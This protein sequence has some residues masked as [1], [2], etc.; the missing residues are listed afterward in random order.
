MIVSY[1]FGA[2]AVTPMHT[3]S[4]V[5][6]AGYSFLAALVVPIWSRTTQ[7]L[8]NGEFAWVRSAIRRVGQISCVF[9]LGFVAVA[10]IYEELSALWLGKRLD[11]QPGVIGATCLFYIMEAVNLIH[12]QFYY[13]MGQIK[14]YMILTIF[15]AAAIIPLS[16]VMAV[17]LGLGVAGVKLA[18]SVVLA[19]SG[20]ALPFLTR[21]RL[22]DCEA[23]WEKKSSADGERVRC[24]CV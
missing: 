7:A 15:Q 1:L 12:V 21:R 4:T 24:Q 23:Q 2:K 20:I 18:A 14:P 3:V 22:K 13:G 17:P 9:I 6:A 5:Y 10:F 16:W 19:V 8:E 11:Y